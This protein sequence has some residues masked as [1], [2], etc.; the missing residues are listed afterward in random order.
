MLNLVFFF[1]FN[2]LLSVEKEHVAYDIKTI[3]AQTSAVRVINW[4]P[5]LLLWMPHHRPAEAILPTACSQ[6]L[7]KHMGVMRQAHS[8]KTWD[9]SSRWLW[10]KDILASWPNFSWNCAAID[11]SYPFVL[12]SFTVVR[13]ASWS[14]SS[15]H[16]LLLPPLSFTGTDSSESLS[17]L[18][19]PWTCSE[20]LN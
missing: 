10:L 17:H 4:Q 16:L 13:S 14:E 8:C 2:H 9:F 7:T 12:P 19:L 6:P 5:Q 3:I 20:D 1:F 15:P 18:I 11:S